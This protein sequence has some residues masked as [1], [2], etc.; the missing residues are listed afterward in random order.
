V[1]S[2][3]LREPLDAVAMFFLLVMFVPD[4]QDKRD[5]SERGK[6]E[7]VAWGLGSPVPGFGDAD[8]PP[9]V[10]RI[11]EVFFSR[12]QGAVQRG[13]DASVFPANASCRQIVR[14]RRAST[15][16]ASAYERGTICR[17]DDEFKCKPVSARSDRQSGADGPCT[18]AVWVA[19]RVAQVRGYTCWRCLS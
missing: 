16:T 19:R 3:S 8:R 11:A 15:H 9:P 18:L 13:R 4:G 14:F 6:R 17:A 12:G 10:G 7:T 5:H 2:G 1:Q